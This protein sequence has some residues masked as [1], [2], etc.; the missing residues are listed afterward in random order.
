MKITSVETVYV[1]LPLA[2]MYRAGH[3]FA[4]DLP[5]REYTGSLIVM[6]HTDE[7]ITGIGDIIVK[8]G[9]PGEGQ[10]AKL[11]LDNAL[12]PLL[13][14][15]DPF[16]KE[17]HLR[18]LWEANWHQSTVFVAGL[19]I[20]MHDL[21]GKALGVPVYKLLGGRTR[22]KVALTWNVPADKDINVMVRQAAEA[23]EN[24]FTNVIKIKTGTPW[25]VPAMVAIQK[26]IGPEVPLRPDDNG[27]FLA[28]D[29]I[30][31]FKKARDQGAVYELLEQ[32]APNS[33]LPGLRRVAEALGERVMYHIGHIRREV[34]DTLISH[35]YCDVASVPVFRHGLWQAAQLV[36]AF[37]VASI[38]CA[39]GSGVEGTIAATAA[40]HLATALKNMSYPVDTLGPLW[41]A[42]DIV[43]E[44]PEFAAGFAKAPNAPGL[45]LELDWDKI[46]KYRLA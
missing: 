26:A 17:R 27:T 29:A 41:F 36:N 3:A 39:M 35:K 44:R 12:A 10:A 42:D 24:G 30:Q 19:D 22:E 31:R 23:V 32:P 18:Q 45:G 43:K 40:I 28:G 4:H 6:L 1:R 46:E 11:Y 20:A 14:G 8:G 16:N 38:G 7:G 25:D 33:D 21:L 5:G 9:R 13:I 34:A 15:A 2:F 37:E